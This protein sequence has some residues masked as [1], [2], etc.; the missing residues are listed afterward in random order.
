MPK[1]YYAYNTTICVEK[2]AS[3]VT[4]LHR[5]G[6]APRG[7]KGKLSACRRRRGNRAVA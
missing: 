7:K 5:N 2:V 3:P 1:Q 4:A 6:L